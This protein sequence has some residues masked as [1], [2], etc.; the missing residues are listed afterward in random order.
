MRIIAGEWGGQSIAGR[1][2]P[3]LRPTADKVKEAIFDI[4]EARFLKGWADVK[5]LDLFAGFGGLGLEALSRGALSATFID[6]HLLT[7][8]Q[9]ESNLK[10]FN[11]S[12]RGEVHCRGA[13]EA[14]RWLS[15]RGDRFDLVFLDPPYREDWVTAC[16]NTM[17]DHP[18]LTRR[19]LLIAEHDKRESLTSLQGLW[20]VEDSRRYGDTA[21]SILRAKVN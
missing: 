3:K 21:I 14:I 10:E 16:L 17:I 9:L 7:C 12:E 20:S 2:H 11:A 15:A 18:L 13:L 5:V 8:K 1:A 6:H 19:A 4:L